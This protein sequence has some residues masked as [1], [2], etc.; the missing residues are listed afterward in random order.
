MNIRAYVAFEQ[1][2]PEFEEMASYYKVIHALQPH[3]EHYD[4]REDLQRNRNPQPGDQNSPR[5]RVGCTKSW[6]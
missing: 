6:R 5:S 2:P 1:D 3:Q 4:C